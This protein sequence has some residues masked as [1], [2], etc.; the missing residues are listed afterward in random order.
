MGDGQRAPREPRLPRHPSG[1]EAARQAL[2]VRGGSPPGGRDRRRL[3]RLV[4]GLSVTAPAARSRFA[5]IF[6]TILVDLIGFGIIIPILPYYA[7][8]LGAGGLGLGALLSVF[9]AMQFVATAFL[10]RT[11]D[12]VGRRPILL[13]TMLVNALGYVLFAAAHSYAVLFV[14]RVVSGFAGGNISAAQAYMA[15]ITTPAERSRGMGIIGAAFGLGFIIGPAVGGLSAHYLGPSAPGLVAAGLSLINFVSAYFVLP[16]SLKAEHRTERELWD[17]SHIG[18]AIRHPRLAPLMIAWL[19]APFAFSGYTVAIPFWAGLSFGWKEQQLGWF[20][21]VI[22]ATAAVVQGYVFGKLARRF[23]ERA[24]L[25]AGGCGMAVAIAVIP[26][27]HSSAALYA[28]TAILAFANSIFGPAAT[29]L[30]SVFAD[31]TEQ[32]TVLGAAQ[33]LAALGRLLG[34]L[35]LGRVYDASHPAAFFVAAAVMALGGLVCLRVPQVAD[36]ETARE[37]ARR[38]DV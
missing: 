19:L 25:I 36:V 17:F 5:V 4:Q 8:R 24:L 2:A 27:L 34:P 13:T 12:R 30:V 1:L 28:W 7:Q 15:D 3:A 10:G 32:G 20:F 14:A 31:P 35:T 16:E 33:A 37:T 21:S 22:G 18:D 29:G 23:G 9:S 6:F 38:S 11:S 26:A